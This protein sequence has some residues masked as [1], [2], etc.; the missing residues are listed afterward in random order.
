MTKPDQDSL[1]RRTIA[2]AFKAS[3][4]DQAAKAVALYSK[5]IEAADSSTLEAKVLST[6]H[7]NRGFALRQLKR[8][9]EA[10]QDYKKASALDPA[11]FEPHLNAA[12]IYAQ[13]FGQYETGLVEFDKAFELNPMATDVLSSRGLTKQH[14]GDLAGAEEDLLAALSIESENVDFLFNLGMLYLKRRQTENA[15]KMFR[16]ALTIAPGDME[17][18]RILN[19]TLEPMPRSVRGG[20]T[21]FLRREWAFALFFIGVFVAISATL[22]AN[23]PLAYVCSSLVSALVF[24][25]G[26]AKHDGSPIDEAT[27]NRV[28][29]GSDSFFEREDFMHK[30]EMRMMLRGSPI[31]AAFCI[32]GWGATGLLFFTGESQ[33]GWKAALLFGAPWGFGLALAWYNI[34]KAWSRH[35]PPLDKAIL[36]PERSVNKGTPR[37]RHKIRVANVVI[38]AIL[39]AAAEVGT[40][41]VISHSLRDSVTSRTANNIWTLVLTL[42]FATFWGAVQI[43]KLGKGNYPIYGKPSFRR[44]HVMAWIL[45]AIVMLGVEA[46][47]IATSG[48]VYLL[49]YVSEVFRKV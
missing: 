33:M 19:A 23:A 21:P 8:Q 48:S 26:L 39:L 24:K 5:A 45:S 30:A 38:I 35:R 20:H 34:A 25:P 6:C 18:R 41:A 16:K 7:L 37:L 46:Y 42:A 27:V 10:L 40:A 28:A 44:E 49:S 29:F 9:H 11:S 31:F 1:L 47:S 2:D 17:I 12:L 43:S 22:G 13:D 32:I 4:K 3:E 36:G 15:V 14:L